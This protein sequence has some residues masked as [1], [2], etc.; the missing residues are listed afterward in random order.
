MTSADDIWDDL[1]H[2]CAW[3]AYIDQ[4]RAEQGPP[5][6]ETTRRRAFRYYEEEVARK[7]RSRDGRRGDG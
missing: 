4:A 2:G 6:S 5:D 3:A 1:F 7:D